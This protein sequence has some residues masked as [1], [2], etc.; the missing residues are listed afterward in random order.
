MA[1]CSPLVKDLDAR[2]ERHGVEPSVCWDLASWKLAPRE[3]ESTSVL[4]RLGRLRRPLRRECRHYFLMAAVLIK[5]F[6]VKQTEGAQH[7]RILD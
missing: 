4:G 1:V 6:L 3:S 7:R 2:A 5:A